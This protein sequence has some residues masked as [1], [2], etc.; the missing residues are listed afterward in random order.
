MVSGAELDS[1]E[2]H[3]IGCPD[4]ATPAE[5]AADYVDPGSSWAIL[6]GKRGTLRIGARTIRATLGAGALSATGNNRTVTD[7]ATREAVTFRG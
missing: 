5:E 3:V 7:L 4:C 1:L 6:T 2:E